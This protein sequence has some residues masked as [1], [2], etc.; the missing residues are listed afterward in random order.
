LA[1]AVTMLPYVRVCAAD[2]E[3]TNLGHVRKGQC[4]VE[5]LHL[6]YSDGVGLGLPSL[7]E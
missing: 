6:A 1:N 4:R 3:S 2:V 7:Q 5:R